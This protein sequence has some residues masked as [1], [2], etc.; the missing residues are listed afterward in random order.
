MLI[1]LLRVTGA[2]SVVKS[3][4]R[5]LGSSPSPGPL[6]GD[7]Y[8]PAGIVPIADLRHEAAIRV[9]V[10]EVPAAPL[11]QRLIEAALE[12][13]IGRF[14]AAVLMGHTGIVPG[15]G[16]PVVAGQRVIAAGE[17]ELGVPIEVLER[18]RQR[19]GPVFGGDALELPQRFLQTLGKGAEALAAE[20]YADMFPAAISQAEMVEAVGKGLAVEG[21]AQLVGHGEVGQALEPWLVAL[22]EEHLLVVGTMQRPPVA[23]PPLQR[24]PDTIRHDV[25][26]E[27][28]LQRLENADGH[29]PGRPLQHIERAGPN[30]DEWV[31]PCP[32]RPLRLALRGKLRILIDPTSRALADAGHRRRGGLG[33]L[34]AFGHVKPYLCVGDVKA[35]HRAR[36]GKEQI[37]AA[38]PPS[39]PPAGQ[40]LPRRG[41]RPPWPVSGR[42]LSPSH[43]LAVAGDL[44]GNH[45]CR[46]SGNPNRRR[47][48]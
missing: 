25:R 13:A 40:K 44:T 14:D 28:L 33:V 18:R 36:I 19:I 31:R 22:G 30:S 3:V 23:D 4:V 11:Q 20:D 29:Q 5:C 48:L 21:D 24:A 38:I 10:V 45:N 47:A 34:G 9:E 26:P 12:M 32:P 43:P 39:A 1:V 41:P 6:G 42:G 46:W 37:R 35:G 17:V 15:G 7:Q 27:L 8:A 16:H 2:V